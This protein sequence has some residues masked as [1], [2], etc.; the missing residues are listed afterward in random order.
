MK[1]H[2]QKHLPKNCISESDGIYLYQLYKSEKINAHTVT[3]DFSGVEYCS[4]SFF[5]AFLKE[6]PMHHAAHTLTE[7]LVFENMNTQIKY[8]FE[9][10]KEHEL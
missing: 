3:L 9:K 1:V 7:H 8:C 4:V 10:A 5:V 2:V 6:F